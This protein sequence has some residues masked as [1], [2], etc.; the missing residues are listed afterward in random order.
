MWQFVKK[1]IARIIYS[2]PVW[3]LIVLGLLAALQTTTVQTYL[4]GHATRYLSEKI[5]FP[6]SIEYLNV[7]WPDYVVLRNVTILDR[8]NQRMIEAGELQVDFQ[9]STLIDGKN[10]YLDKVI[11]KNAHVRLIKSKKTNT[12]NMDEFVAVLDKLVNPPRKTKRIG[13]PPVFQIDQ[14]WLNNVQ[15]SYNDQRKDSIFDG[16]DYQHFT[17][18]SIQGMAHRLRF[19]ADTIQT[20]IESLQGQDNRT[21]LDI[22]RFTTNFLYTR[23]N[24]ELAQLKLDIGNSSIRE[25]VSFKYDKPADLSDF[26]AKVF[27][28]ADLRE[29]RIYSKD[30]ALFAPYLNRYEEYWSVS[31]KFNGLVGRFRLRNADL[32]FGQTSQVKGNISFEGLPNFKET[33]IDFDLKPSV[34]VARDLEQYLDTSAYRTARK[35]GTVRLTGKFLGF[36]Q[37]FVANGSFETDLGTIVSNINLK[38]SGNSAKTAYNGHLTTRNFDLGTLTDQPKLVQRIDMDGDIEGKGLRIQD[39]D[40]RIKAKIGRIGYQFYD[41]RRIAVDGQLSRQQFNG[42]VSIKDTNLVFDATGEIDLRNGH[43]LVNIRADLQKANLKEL[44][45]TTEEAIVRTK[46]DVNIRGL[47]L[48]DI[49]GNAV[50]TEGYILFDNKDLVIDSLRIHSVKDS[51][52]RIFQVRS[53]FADIDANGNFDFTRLSSDFQQLLKE[54]RLNFSNNTAETKKYYAAKRQNPAPR[55]AL[56][57]SVLLKDINPLLLIFYPDWSLSQNTLIEGRFSKGRTA[58]V[59]LHSTIDTLSYKNNI[60]YTNEIDINTSKLSDSTTVLAATYLNSKH[61]KIGTAK[62]ENLNMEAIWN[63]K[64]IEFSSRIKQATNDNYANLRGDVQFLSDRITLKFKP[65]HLQA[66]QNVWNIDANNLI[67]IRGREITFDNLQFTNQYQFIS[68]NGV[69]SNDTTKTVRLALK[70]FGLQSLNPLIDHQ[71]SGVANGFL[72]I[73]D[74]YKNRNIESELTI[75]ELVV[76]KFL[77]GDIIGESH[78]NE[79]TKKI[80]ANYQVYRMDQRIVRLYGTYDPRATEN[81]L[82]MQ[83]VLDRANLEILEPFFSDQVSRIGGTASGTLS[84]TGML[85]APILKGEA[86]VYNGRFRYNYLN[87]LYYFDDK[88]RFNSNEISVKN[89]Q[90]RDEDDNIAVLNGGVFHDG[91]RNF[92]LSLS[93][94]MRNFKVLNTTLKD[95]K[96]FYGTAYV[97]GDMEL[98]G[99]IE[100]LTIRANARSNKGTKISIPISDTRTIA[101][102]DFIRFAS[103][104]KPVVADAN[105]TE[106][107][108]REQI[109]LRGV[110]M[111]FNFDITPDAYCEIIFDEKAGDI[112][113]GNG[114]GRIKMEIDTKGDFRM[115]GNYTISKGAY[116]FTLLNAVNKAF[117]IEPGGTVSWTGDPYEG[118]L[119]INAI[120]TQQASILPILSNN[121]KLQPSEEAEARRRYPVTVQMKLTGNLLT[122]KIDLGIDFKNFPQNSQFYVNVMDFKN[123]VSTNE[124]ELNR[125]VFSL[126]ILNRLSSENFSGLGQGSVTSSISEF[127]TNQLSYWASQVN[128]NLQ[129]DLN[130]SGLDSEA[131][132]AFQLRLSYAALDGRLRITRDGGFTTVQS[133]QDPTARAVSVIGDWTVEYILNKTGS[134]RIKMFNRNSQNV[135]NSATVGTTTGVVAGFSLLHTESFN[136][137]WELFHPRRHDQEDIEKQIEDETPN[138]VPP[139]TS[140]VNNRSKK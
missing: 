95:N 29:T 113:R 36:P 93:G 110:L 104:I 94:R 24:I 102:Q 118:I 41:Y 89:L 74:L 5:G 96:L 43:N 140:Q 15:F 69:V 91:F 82:D 42:N 75:E 81:A 90:L 88:I 44:K 37:D 109:D 120:Y 6:L 98:L 83:A 14:A 105:A 136:S 17:I 133:T 64:H 9:W 31:G 45:F 130:L 47:K 139:S 121:G 79:T 127:L 16:F 106:K 126:L 34:I 87:T 38:T 62:T 97:T 101:E 85:T 32:Q 39:A 103:K 73:K 70:E 71:I 134:L 35:F 129:I 46:V 68:L 86:S 99:S 100:N 131:W 107:K 92:V 10:I 115:F 72:E 124:Q 112:I 80:N 84:L 116:N 40:F 60:F 7:R 114:S 76:D 55:Y 20:S 119:D 117:A 52:Q 132:N 125:Q 138:K 22:H 3:M 128:E 56:D 65:S 26:V 12:L 57:Y 8:E 78:W 48:D 137:L 111:D 59:S 28:K 66:F 63:G 108:K 53:S 1:L 33:L 30:L 61:Q 19:V 11:L 23:Q 2:I 54:Y 58:I 25:L 13:P 49:V 21:N 122:P 123:R 135:F 4:A 18:D 67:S 50:F 51:G 27:I 77:V